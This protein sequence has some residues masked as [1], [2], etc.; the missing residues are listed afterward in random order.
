[1]LETTEEFLHNTL[2]IDY[3]NVT[4]LGLREVKCYS[5]IHT[6]IS[7]IIRGLIQSTSE[8]FHCGNL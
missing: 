7:G 1:M 2:V 8:S 4:K 6:A 5:V 3:L